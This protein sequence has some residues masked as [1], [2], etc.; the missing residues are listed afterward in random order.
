MME[1]LHRLLESADRR[2]GAGQRTV[3][4]ALI[5]LAMTV[6]VALAAVAWPIV[7]ELYSERITAGSREAYLNRVSEKILRALGA[8]MVTRPKQDRAESL[9][10]RIAVERDGGLISAEIVQPSGNRALD[11][12]ALRIVRE[13]APFEAFPAEMRGGTTSVEIISTFNFN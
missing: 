9:Q 10:L 1:R 6:T 3:R 13:S 7:V 2:L 5:L 4:A 8:A 11:E 12:L